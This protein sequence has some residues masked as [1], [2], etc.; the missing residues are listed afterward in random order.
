MLY[1]CLNPSYL[2]KLKQVY[3]SLECQSWETERYY[4][5]E[6]QLKGWNKFGKFDAVAKDV[7]TALKNIKPVKKAAKKKVAKKAVK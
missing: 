1:L 4:L 5:S 7:E 2:L 6:I 3:D